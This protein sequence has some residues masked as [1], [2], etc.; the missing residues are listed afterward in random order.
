MRTRALVLPAV[1][2]I[3][4]SGTANPAAISTP[5]NAAEMADA[6]QKLAQ[7]RDPVQRAKRRA[8]NMALLPLVMTAQLEY[9]GLNQQEMQRLLEPLSDSS[10]QLEESTLECRIKGPCDTDAVYVEAQNA[11][12]R[13]VEQAAGPG[14]SLRFRKFGFWSE[15]KRFQQSLPAN[16]RISDEVVEQLAT[17]LMEERLRTAVPGDA[18]NL[19]HRVRERATLIL[20]ADQMARFI[21]LHERW[22]ADL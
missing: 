10:L 8:T 20:T 17:V 22:F 14:G 11:V 3:F 1:T 2:L 15:A 5:L 6:Q 21:E 9:T 4:A 12:L 13:L 7:L 16:R 19:G 18:P